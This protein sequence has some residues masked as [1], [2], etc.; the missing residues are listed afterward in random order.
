MTSYVQLR[1]DPLPPTST[2]ELLQALLGDDPSLAPLTP[3]LMARTEGNPFFLEESV[4][5]LVETGLLGGEPGA[6]R[7]EQPLHRLHVPA[8]VQAVLAARID[9]LPP[10]EKRLLQT[11]AVMGPE[12]PLPLLQ[13][14]AELPE[15]ALYRSLTHLQVAEFLYETRLF[16]EH[17]YTFKHA[18]TQ[19]V[20]YSS[21]LLVQRRVLH[22]RIVEALEALAGDRV[23]EHVE[24]LAHHAL[25][26]VWAKAVAYARQ[27]GRKPWH[28]RPTA[29]PRGT[30]SR[31]SAPCRICRRRAPRASRPSISG[32]PCARRSNRLAT[33]GACWCLREA[34]AVA[35]TL[36]DPHRLARSHSFCHAIS[37]SWARMTRPSSP[38]NAPS[39]LLRPVGM[40]SCTRSRTS[41]SASLTSPRATIG[42]RSTA[43]GRP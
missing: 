29:Q 22:S 42:G 37:P 17:A 32:S 5:T 7:L 19:E 38:P 25:R 34:E 39:R 41:T 24:R 43:A 40:V 36:D 1:L 30:L 6:Y 20:A 9:R 11:A 15:E 8:T 28:G 35:E 2:D 3:L 10:G 12:V 4:R 31:R 33:W 23:A 21:L 13:A 26:G 18:L 14:I 27:A 16:P